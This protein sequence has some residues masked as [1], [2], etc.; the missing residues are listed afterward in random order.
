VKKGDILVQLDSSDATL[1]LQE[2]E[3]QIV[4][5]GVELQR[6]SI[7]LERRQALKG[8]GSV[9]AD[10]ITRAQYA[11]DMAKANLETAKAKKDQ[12]KLEL[13][14]TVI[15]APVSGV[16]ARRQVQLGQ[17]ISSGTLLLTVV[18]VG[19]IHVDANFKENQLAGVAT[20]QSAKLTSD[21][22]GSSVV[23]HGVV[24]G[25][26]AGTGSAFAAIPAQ[27]ATGNWIKVVQRVPV[28]IKLDPQE[29]AKYPLKVGMSMSVEIDKSSH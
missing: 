9:T 27:N 1:K 14:R 10:E 7:D 19:E 17:R 29:L 13:E 18:P 21:V 26:S 15:A 20:G 2:V 11:F 6:A 23:Y 5:A 25:F 4:A 28:R 22:Y 16:V 24:D 12:V 3:T 8:T